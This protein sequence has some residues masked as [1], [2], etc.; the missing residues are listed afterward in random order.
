M[1]N[2]L[3][4]V[5][6]T[7][8]G[9]IG[10]FLL[11]L[12]DLFPEAFDL[13]DIVLGQVV[14][15]PPLLA[16]ITNAVELKVYFLIDHELVLLFNFSDENGFLIFGHCLHFGYSVI[17]LTIRYRAVDI[18]YVYRVLR[19]LTGAFITLLLIVAFNVLYSLL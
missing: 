5:S 17:H 10:V 18:L 6:I 19:E 3:F 11:D 13:F 2:S 9:P 8:A 15:R 16:S 4:S 12:N 7:R 1:S 14:R